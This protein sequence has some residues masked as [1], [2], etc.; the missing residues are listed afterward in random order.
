MASQTITGDALQFTQDNK[1]CFG[2]SGLIGVD[3]N[4]TVLLKLITNSE[5]VLGEFNFN[6]DTSDGDDMRYRVLI[7]D[8]EVQGWQHD[9][10]ARGFRNIAKIIIPPF[11]TVK[12]TATNQTGDTSRNVL[13][14]F[15]GRVYE[16]LAVRN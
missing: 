14:S 15:T 9:Y 10:S 12:A 6:K 3:D 16:M 8:I 7:D 4:E 2:Y 5:T 13:C 1:H 11:S